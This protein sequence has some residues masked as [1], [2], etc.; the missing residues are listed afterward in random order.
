M[1]PDRLRHAPWLGLVILAL[2]VGEKMLAHTYTAIVIYVLP[3]PW[4]FWVPAVIGALGVVLIIRGLGRNEVVGTMHG[5]LGSV[6]IW[7]SWFEPMLPRI[8]SY[9]EIPRFLPEEG[10]RMAGLLGEH[11]ILQ[12]SSLFCLMLVFFL[13]LNK[14]V[15]CR[16]MLWLRRRARL[17]TGRPTAG[18]RPNVARV[19][20]FEYFAVTWFMYTVMLV[21][22]DPRLF[23]LYH[24]VTWAGTAVLTAWGLYLG[25]KL[26]FQR[27]VGLAI[28]Y[29]IGAVGVLWFI[30]EMAALYEVFY[31]FYIYAN[32]H[33]VAVT[34]I[35]LG[36]LY[37]IV[38]LYRTPVNPETQRSI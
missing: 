21:M 35:L 9:N 2:M 1:F 16:M 24:P 30:P 25:F 36:F 11:V 37:T 23:G 14:D 20:A 3:D 12:S 17:N 29:G 10:N 18:Y 13:T 8:A 28:R 22:I 33:P 26:C 38:L 32:R 5:Y 34:A 15:R 6:L 4:G 19:A 31:E 7:M 27:E